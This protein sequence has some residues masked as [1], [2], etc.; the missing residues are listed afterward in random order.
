MFPASCS[1][2]VMMVR[3]EGLP[4]PV[5]LSGEDRLYV[6]GSNGIVLALGLDCS[7][8][9]GKGY[10]YAHCLDCDARREARANHLG[11]FRWWPRE[12]E[13]R[14]PF[15]PRGHEEDVIVAST[16]GMDGVGGDLE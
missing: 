13:A 6:H 4:C 9:V 1:H 2:A 14:V 5:R 7:G 16:P 3:A 12:E 15:T 11:F 8:E 10:V